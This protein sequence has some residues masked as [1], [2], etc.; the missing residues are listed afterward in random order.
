VYDRMIKETGGE[1]GTLARH[2]KACEK[3]VL[4]EGKVVEYK[5]E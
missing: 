3:W 4:G 5:P 1:Q 2:Y